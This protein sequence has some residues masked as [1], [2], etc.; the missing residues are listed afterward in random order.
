MPFRGRDVVISVS[1]ILADGGM[2]A[3]AGVSSVAETLE[4][5]LKPMIKPK[6]DA[7]SWGTAK[8]EKR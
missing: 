3:K 7:Q 6:H 4:L 8:V 2:P 5:F 1:L